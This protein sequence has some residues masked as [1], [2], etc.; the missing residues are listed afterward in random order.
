MKLELV[1]RLGEGPSSAL[2]PMPR[3]VT[4]EGWFLE[5]CIRHAVGLHDESPQIM[6]V[7]TDFPQAL[8]LPA[9]L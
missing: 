8:V 5:G 4:V 3:S 1:S 9:S 2:E 6:L 7:Q